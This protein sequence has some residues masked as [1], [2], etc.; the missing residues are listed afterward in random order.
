M[1][2]KLASVPESL[3][4]ARLYAV[5]RLGTRVDV[6]VLVEV[7]PGGKGLTAETTAELLE[8][9]METGDMLVE[10]PVGGVPFGAE[11]EGAGMSFF[12]HCHY[13]PCLLR[14]SLPKYGLKTTNPAFR[15]EET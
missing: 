15:L 7:L 5:K 9:H 13:L 8:F 4:T 12:L 11:G 2:P 3:C 1:L 14:L 6:G 10:V